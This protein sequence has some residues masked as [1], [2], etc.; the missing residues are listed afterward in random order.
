M[1]LR[2][3]RYFV[4]VAQERHIGRAARRLHM[5]QPPLSR[6]IRELEDELG[7]TLFERTS[8][9]VTL[10]AAGTVMYEESV[11]LLER[12]DLLRTRVSAAAGAAAL[13]IGTLAD[14]AEL[15]AGTLVA[16]FRERHPSVEVSIREAD[17]ADPTA[18]LRAGLVDVALTRTPFEDNG[19][20]VRI[21]RR[22]PVGVVLRED[23]PLAGRESV[24]A[25][26]LTGRR[27]VRLPD[28]ADPVWAAYWTG[29]SPEGS[30]PIVRTIQECL[31]AVLW[32]TTCA[33]APADQP[34]PAGLVVVP[35]RDRPPSHLVVAHAKSTPGPLVRS[36]VQLAVDSFR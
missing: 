29:G 8:K 36:F 17:L 2:S 24:S 28:N 31:Q 13:T 3:L 18:G 35:F 21:L 10:T 9:G 23:D 12:A 34:L 16:R 27:W 26:D 20:G 33:L 11:A 15:V 32:N 4:A 14:T 7:V 6:A 19:I 25:A 30:A 22:I 1:D 5:T